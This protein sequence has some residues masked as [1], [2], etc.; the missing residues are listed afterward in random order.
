MSNKAKILVVEDNQVNL[1]LFMDFLNVGGYECIHATKGED[2]IEIARKEN[3]DLVLLDIQLPGVDGLT[4]VKTLKSDEATKNI[5][6]IALTAYAM[7]GDKEMF[8][9]KGFDGYIPKP[10]T[11]K[12]FLDAIAGYYSS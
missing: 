9:D 3:P 11:M 7:K 2:A 8:L 4:V 6:V 12:K 1:E 5:K 10:I